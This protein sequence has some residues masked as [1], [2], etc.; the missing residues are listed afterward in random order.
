M[1]VFVDVVG[2]VLRV[3]DSYVWGPVMVALLVGTGVFLTIRLKFLP[4]R[5]LGYALH[6]VFG[7]E[8]RKKSANGDISPFSALMTA[9]AATIGTG[10]IVGVATA[11][12]SGGPGALVWMWISAL[13]GLTTK[14]SECMLAVKYREKN[15]KGEMCGGPM[16]T[17][18]NAFKRHKKFGLVLG[19]LFAVF[20]LLASFGVGNITQANSI[21][22]AF[23]NTFGVPTWVVGLIITVLAFI[24]LMGGIKSIS[25]VSSVLVPVMAVFYV[26]AGLICIVVNIQNVPAGLAEIVRMAFS[27]TAVGG[28]IAG[29]IVASM[30]DA[31]KYGSAR[32]VFSNEAGLGSAAITAAAAT[33]TRPAKQGYVNMTG[34]FF[35][36]LVVCSIT[37]LVIASSGVLGMTDANGDL[38]TGSN[39]TIVA[40]RN[41]FAR[42][43]GAAFGQLGAYIVTISIALF[44]FSTIIGWEY[45]GEKALEFL[46]P[47]QGACIAYRVIF[48]LVSFIGATTTLQIVWD[49]SDIANAL[50]AIPNLISLLLL[51]GVIAKE[52]FAFQ[53]DTLTPGRLARKAARLRKRS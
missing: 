13:F 37:G 21:S 7:K 38:V 43:G 29:T 52:V 22:T 50:M 11:M 28:G 9:L 1:Q 6:M 24:I 25:R 17:M 20:A 53:E 10:N 45:H 2:Q 31:V 30:M 8:S 40:F 5:N 39:L 41:A 27:P 42:I 32:G 47:K 34:T 15:E 14:Y 16:Y 12:V 48:A 35:D 18:K 19:T 4:W 44:A 46:I 26:F 49:F 33:T 36:T 51:S 23:E 3:V